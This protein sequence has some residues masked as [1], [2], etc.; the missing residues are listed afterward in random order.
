M[1]ESRA[2]R[3]QRR[4]CKERAIFIDHY[5]MWRTKQNKKLVLK[6]NFKNEKMGLKDFFLGF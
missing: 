2:F 5:C 6:E 4:N 1:N 3:L